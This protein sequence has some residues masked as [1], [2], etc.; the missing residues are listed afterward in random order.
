MP[1]RLQVGK[2]FRP[3]F[4]N[5]V[6]EYSLDTV[7]TLVGMNGNIGMAEFTNEDMEYSYWMWYEV[8]EIKDEK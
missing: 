5:N 7:L 1:E 8:N 3:R 2:K 4:L 6:Y